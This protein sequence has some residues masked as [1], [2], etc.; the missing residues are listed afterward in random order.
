[1]QL[2]Q[3]R[4]ESKFG[5]ISM[6]TTEASLDIR[7]PKADLSIEQP[8]AVMTIDKRP[9]KLEIDQTKAFEDMNLMNILRRNDKFAEEGMQA[10]A[11]GTGRRAAEGTEL[12]RIENGGN[13]LITQAVNY[14]FPPQKELGIKFIPSPFSVKINYDPGDVEINIEPQKPKI[15]AKINPPQFT[16]HPGKV[17]IE[18]AQRPELHIDFVNLFPEG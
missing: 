17:D 18:L 10:I 1:M 3:I 15:D 6:Q 4:M 13:P 12:M 7:Q 5:Q 11:E 9:P 14:A 8:Q 16:Y 2:P